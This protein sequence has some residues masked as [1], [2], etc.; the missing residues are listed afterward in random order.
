M[1]TP[2]PPTPRTFGLPLRARAAALATVGVLLAYDLATLAR[3]LGVY[4]S[5]ELAL[6]AVQLGLSHPIGQPLHTLLGAVF[7][8]LP[9]VPPL[10]GLSFFSALAHALSAIPVLSI[11]ETLDDA[12]SSSRLRDGARAALVGG[13]L[14]A[15]PI[16]EAATRVEVYTLSGLLSCWALA[17][18]MPML[19]ETP[20]RSRDALA[21]GLALGLLGATNAYHA[22]LTALAL[23]PAL[24]AALRARTLGPGALAALVGGGMLGLLLYLY[25]PLVAGRTDVVV[26]GAPTTPGALLAYFRGADYAHNRGIDAITF[27]THALTWLRWSFTAGVLP[28]LLV[29]LAGHALFGARRGLGRSGAALLALGTVGLLCSHAVFHPDITDYVNYLIPALLVAAAGTGALV[30]NLAARTARG[31]VLATLLALALLGA[32]LS[33]SPQVFARTRAADH[34]ARLLAEGAL[35]EAPRGAILV[36]GPDH[37]GAPLL[38]VQEIE[39]RRPDVVLVLHGLASSS[40]YWDH[41]RRRH[42]DLPRFALRGPGGR[43][44]RIR[45]LLD[46]APERAVHVSGPEIAAGLGLA[47]CDVGFLAR[48]RPCGPPG[49]ASRLD[50]SA[51]N[52]SLAAA[53]RAVDTGSPAS[54]GA[55][56]AVA[57]VRGTSLWRL[58]RPASAMH[59]LLAGVPPSLRP[60]TPPLDP[61]V[62]R[63]AP[64]LRAPPP[65]WREPAALGDPRRALFL[66]ALLAHAAG[67]DEAALALASRA[68]ALGLPEAQ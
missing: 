66:A 51:A 15:W 39:R 49:A 11:A 8:H 50:A 31:P 1:T 52:R 16:W 34:A 29:G 59:A 53:M 19:R 9:G 58:G 27:A 43:E 12:P 14:L 61:A 37:W 32:T 26:W 24:I 28:A 63:H 25:V 54:D 13:L 44:G 17:R 62:L 47:E 68:A 3:D 35:A 41:L 18:A 46:A 56:A 36:I 60:A 33:A 57:V 42:P 40:W 21:V 23:S 22:V 45:R 38:Y 67:A 5:A 10:V 2:T 48:V 6:V 7:S 30:L 55:L 4:D 65:E 64:P 20:A